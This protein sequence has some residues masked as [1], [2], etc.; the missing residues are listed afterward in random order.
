MFHRERWAQV[1]NYPCRGRHPA[2]RADHPRLL[3]EGHDPEEVLLVLQSVDD[4]DGHVF[5]DGDLG[6]LLSLVSLQQH[7][8]AGVN[9]TDDA[10]FDERHAPLTLGGQLHHPLHL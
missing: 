1:S 6:A 4:V 3:P 8:S 7:A 9:E 2:Q 10:H 5:Q